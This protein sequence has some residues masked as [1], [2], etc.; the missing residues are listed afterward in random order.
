MKVGTDGVLLG[1]WAP[2]P[3][4]RIPRMLDIGTGSGL[5]ALMLAQRCPDAQIE[6]IDMDAAATEQAADNFARSPWS[7]RLH[8]NHCALQD[9]STNTRFD[10]IVSNPPYFRESLRNP[11]AAR[12][13]ARHTDTLDYPELLHHACQLLVPDGTLALILPAEAEAE[14]MRLATT[15]GLVPTRL[16]H[17]FSKPGKPVRRVLAA[18]VKPTKKESVPAVAETL[19]NTDTLYIESKTAPRSEAYARLTRDFYL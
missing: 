9:Y 10:L 17:V 2:L 7:V 18:F 13:T 19:G 16:T 5:I 3:N 12:N 1:A 11:D 15:V 6:A 14:I 4:G 8:A